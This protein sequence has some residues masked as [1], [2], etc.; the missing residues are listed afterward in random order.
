[1]VGLGTAAF[2]SLGP[3]RRRRAARRGDA[4]RRQPRLPAAAAG[5]GGRP[6][7]LGLRAGSPTSSRGCR[8]A[9]SA[10][11]CVRPSCDGTF[12]LGAGARPAASG[13]SS[14][15]SLTVQDVPVGV[16]VRPGDR[17]GLA[18]RQPG[19]AA[20]GR[21]AG[22]QH[23]SSSSPA[24]SCG[25]P[26]PGWAARPGRGAPTSRSRPH[27]ALGSHAAIEFG[28]RMLTF[29]HRR[30]GR[31]HVRRRLAVRASG[32]RAGWPSCSPSGCPPRR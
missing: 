13:P 8:P 21:L 20:G 5:G 30:G 3:L 10:A 9:R 11:G 29:L 7:R 26:A 1:M 6:A 25:S 12:P 17:A 2:A 22:R 19:C 16:T 23:R 24:A 14:G 18:R 28:N 32:A 31:R 27:G 4:G 15:R